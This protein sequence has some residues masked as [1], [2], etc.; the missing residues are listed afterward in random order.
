MRDTAPALDDVDLERRFGGLR[1]L[2]GD[3]AYARIRAAHVVVVGVGG[4][5]S[6][7]AEALARSGIGALTLVDL[8]HV[9]ESN[10]NRQVQALGATLGQAKVEALRARIAD[11]HPGCAVT[12]VDAFVE[13]GNWPG[14]LPERRPVDA[15]VDACDQGR[16]KAVLAAWALAPGA[17]PL[18]IVGAAG[19]KR[20]AQAVA[21]EDLGLL[22]HDPMLAALRQRLRKHHGAARTG[23][24][25]LACVYSR[26]PVRGPLQDAGA[27]TDSD[28]S[29]NCSGYGSSV[30][31]TATFG[32][33]AAGLAL[34]S[35]LAAQGRVGNSRQI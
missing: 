5:G 3:A 13:D 8:D 29:L 20:A 11:I 15:V 12:A 32:M 9:S 10:I 26:E 16:A 34:E 25:G 18:V 19:G 1:R 24:I 6:W 14:L 35:L 17:P 23:R 33:V 28:G 30:A 31:V 21:V 22:T 7:T 2:Y 27:P 4:V